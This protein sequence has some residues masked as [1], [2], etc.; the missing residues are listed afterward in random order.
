LL[1]F[2]Y[3]L[4]I[5]SPDPVSFEALHLPDSSE[6]EYAGRFSR[7][8]RVLILRKLQRL[9]IRVVDWQVDQPLERV[10]GTILRITAV[11]NLKVGIGK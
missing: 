9:G 3:R 8:E 1:A 7:L 11:E 2:G 4:L 5:I 10:L 6:M